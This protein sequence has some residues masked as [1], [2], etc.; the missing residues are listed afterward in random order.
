MAGK[1]APAGDGITGLIEAARAREA[2]AAAAK[3]AA[4]EAQRAAET[5]RQEAVAGWNAIYEHLL[6][7]KR[8]AGTLDS[9]R[10]SKL[11]QLL[12]QVRN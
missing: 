5:A 10:A 1:T 2:T 8:E 6:T 7:L 11:G 12:Q 3:E 9:F 4:L